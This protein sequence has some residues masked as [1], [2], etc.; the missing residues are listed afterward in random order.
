MTSIALWREDRWLWAVA[1]TR[2]SKAAIAGT[3]LTDGGSK[4]FRLNV[5]CREPGSGGFFSKQTF[6]G[7]LGFAFA[8]ASLPALM[9]YAAANACCESLNAP[10]GT[11]PP[12]LMHI[13]QLVARIA[14]RYMRDVLDRNNGREGAFEAAIF[15]LCPSQDRYRAL[16][17]KPTMRDGEFA[18]SVNELEIEAG[19]IVLGTKCHEIGTLILEAQRGGQAR[20]AKFVLQRLIETESIPGVGGAIQIGIAGPNGAFD[21]YYHLR[22]HVV[23]QPAAFR[24]FLGFDLDADLGNV[25]G[26]A[27][28]MMG[29][30]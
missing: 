10:S 15:G 25:G 2:I 4:L 6:S 18:V 29:M 30:V 26:Y 8:G 9:T 27:I 16:H 23:G 14:G 21:L 11:R 28:G 24:S 19:P 13:A 17:V 12:D 7:S 20:A 1:D 3:F 22:P 5:Q